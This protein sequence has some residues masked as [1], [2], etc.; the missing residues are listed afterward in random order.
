MHLNRHH[1]EEFAVVGEN[2]HVQVLN[3]ANELLE[4]LLQ[5]LLEPPETGEEDAPV[6]QTDDA[7]PFDVRRSIALFFLSIREK[8]KLPI[9]AFG[10]R[11]RR[12]FYLCFCDFI[13]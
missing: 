7:T 8:H 4:Q 3:T 13:L 2:V 12:C 5:Q 6:L 10:H 11:V 1:A 9:V